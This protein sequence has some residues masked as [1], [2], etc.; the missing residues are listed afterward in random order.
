MIKLLQARM[1]N[2]WYG[3][4]MM[5]IGGFAATVEDSWGWRLIMVIVAL[6]GA[7]CFVAQLTHDRLCNCGQGTHLKGDS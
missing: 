1:F 3:V 6:S 5:L 7:T 2:Y 4:I